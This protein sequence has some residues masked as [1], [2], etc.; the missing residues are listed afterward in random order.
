MSASGDNL[1][2]IYDVHGNILKTLEPKLNTLH[3]AVV[4]PC[5][6]FVGA[7]GFCPDVFIWEVQFDRGG[8][9][10]GVIR[11]FEL[12]VC[13]AYINRNI[14]IYLGSHFGCLCIRFQSGF[15]ASNYCIARWFMET[16]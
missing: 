16:I 9:F 4:S 12:K 14:N 6:R 5:G 15:N 13:C 1:I 3:R 11:A 8:N 7:S 10:Q 2:I